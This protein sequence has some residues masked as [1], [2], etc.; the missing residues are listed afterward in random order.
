MK[1]KGSK[2]I[3]PDVLRSATFLLVDAGQEGN[4]F[5]G[6]LSLRVMTIEASSDVRNR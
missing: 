3:P 5:C 4:E 1:I 2:Y 6:Q